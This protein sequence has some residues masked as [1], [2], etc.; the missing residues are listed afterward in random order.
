MTTPVGLP[1][2]PL[3]LLAVLPVLAVLL[4]LPPAP[5]PVVLAELTPPPL[6]ALP[7]APPWPSSTNP[8]KFVSA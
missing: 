3:L 7:A 5:L 2:A 1:P 4:V 6:L 8:S